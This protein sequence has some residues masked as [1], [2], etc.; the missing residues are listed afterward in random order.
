MPGFGIQALKYRNLGAMINH[1]SNPNAELVSN[2]GRGAE[3][4]WI[5]ATSYILLLW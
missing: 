5:V 1:S 3:N 4:T 2:Y